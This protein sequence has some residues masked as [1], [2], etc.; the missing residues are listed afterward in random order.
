MSGPADWTETAAR[1]ERVTPLLG[2]YA[3]DEINAEVRRAVEAHLSECAE[4]A[5]ELRVQLAVGNRLGTEHLAE[6]PSASLERLRSHVAGLGR[7]T[8]GSRNGAPAKVRAI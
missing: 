3:D 6:E 4:C 7:T 1:H 5:Q 2:A 8:A